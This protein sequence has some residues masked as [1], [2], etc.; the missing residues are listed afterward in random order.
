M[1]AY[2]TKFETVRVGETDFLIRS[3][4]DHQQFSDPLGQAEDD[5]VSSASWPLFGQVWPSA[6]ILATAMNTHDLVGKRV[7][8]IGAGLALASLVIH[9][10]HGDVT[11]SDY[12]HLSEVFLI[13]NLLLNHLGPLKYAMGNWGG[14]NPALGQFDLIIGSDVLYER[15]HPALLSAFIDRHSAARVEV[16]IV[17]PDRSNRASFCREMASLGYSHS[18]RREDCLQADGRNYKGRTHSFHRAPL[19]S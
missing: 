11:V 14:N 2:Q 6:R 16:M 17:D 19:L 18:E 4:L 12:H 1:P 9:H 7:L 15:D 8:E 3:L 5:G 13:E 10:R